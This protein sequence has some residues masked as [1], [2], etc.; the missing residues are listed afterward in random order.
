MPFFLGFFTSWLILSVITWR[1][2][3]LSSPFWGLVLV[4]TI[5]ALGEL[6]LRFLHHNPV[7]TPTFLG[8]MRAFGE[9]VGAVVN[10][11]LLTL[12]YVAGIGATALLARLISKQFLVTTSSLKSSTYW[13]P[14][15][16]KPAARQQALRQF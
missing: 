4:A 3:N 10:T 12:A 13:Q 16:K 2:F 6:L 7:A 8:G 5:F 9:R 15:A 11:V 1:S 14:A